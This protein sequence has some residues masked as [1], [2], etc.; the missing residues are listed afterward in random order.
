MECVAVVGTTKA[1]STTNAVAVSQHQPQVGGRRQGTV[2]PR[3][4]T[5]PA[6]TPYVKVAQV[7]RHVVIL[8]GSVDQARGS[9]Q[10]R[11]QSVQLKC[12]GVKQPV[13]RLYD[14]LTDKLMMRICPRRLV[15]VEVVEENTDRQ[16][17]YNVIQAG[18]QQFIRDLVA[19]EL[20][21]IET[22]KVVPYGVCVC[23]TWQYSVESIL[24]KTFISLS[25]AQTILILDP[26]S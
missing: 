15:R 23:W 4:Q 8:S 13:M 7:W 25:Q 12:N 17:R 16:D 2:A 19:D 24:V 3:W 9:V 20:M 5:Q 26:F 22:T 14:C 6:D 21:K 1:Q 18:P 10:H 11:L